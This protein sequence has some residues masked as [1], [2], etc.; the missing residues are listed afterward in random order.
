MNP[1]AMRGEPDT[2]IGGMKDNFPETPFSL[3]RSAGGEGTLAKESLSTIIDIYWKP[4]YKHVR[5]RWRRSN[6]DAKDLVQS[7]FAAICEND[8]LAKFD[9]GEAKFRT[10]LKVC[11]DRFIMKQDVSAARLKRGGGTAALDFE[12]A[13]RELAST[14]VESA[15][16][17]FFREWQRQTF[18]LAL[19]DLRRFC[20]ESGKEREYRLFEQYD[21]AEDPRPSYADLAREHNLPVTAVTNHLAWARRNLRRFA[22]ERVASITSGEQELRAEARA[23]FSP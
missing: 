12:A 20:C 14:A 1:D 6:E 22:L 21:L 8:L 5:I 18:A 9:P 15:E 11:L 10:Y 13:E 4:A 19:E 7:F 17:V 2:A 23:L 16:D 3:I